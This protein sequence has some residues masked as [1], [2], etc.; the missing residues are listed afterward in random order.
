MRN[1]Y[2]SRS[3][4]DWLTAVKEEMRRDLEKLTEIAKSGGNSIFAENPCFM[5]ERSKI[6]AL[7]N[8]KMTDMSKYRGCIIIED[9]PEYINFDGETVII[10]CKVRLDFDGDEECYWIK[11]TNEM[12]IDHDVMSCE[13]PLSVCLLGKKVGDEIEFRGAKIKVLEVSLQVSE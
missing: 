11:G 6:V 13:S 12:D 9:M 5:E 4:V 3:K 7:Y 1:Y 10:G 2:A 8:R